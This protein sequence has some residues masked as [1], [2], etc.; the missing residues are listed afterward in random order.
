MSRP[1]PLSPLL[2]QS[3]RQRGIRGF[4]LIELMVLVVIVGVLFAIAIP[5]YSGYLE[6]AKVERAIAELHILQG[7]IMAFRAGNSALPQDLAGINR[8]G[9][10]DPW[11]RPYVY[12]ELI[13]PQGKKK[14]RSDH[15]EHPINSDYDLYSSGADGMS[16]G[17]LTAKPSWDDIIRARDGKYIGLVSKF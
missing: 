10:L 5:A 13:S 14:A 15:F 4:T 3:P 6:R 11:G 8:G 9:F 2:S 1:G 7:E 17:P 16:I 12:Q